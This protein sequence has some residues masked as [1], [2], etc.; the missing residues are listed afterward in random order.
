MSIFYVRK[1]GS[2]TH[3]T[4]LGAY[5]AASAGD[6]INIGEG[7]F[8]ESVEVFKQN[9]TFTG[10]GKD[11]TIIQ[12]NYV[13]GAIS[14]ATGCSWTLGNNFFTYTAQD[15][16]TNYIP[17]AVGMSVGDTSATP[18][19]QGSFPPGSQI[20]SVDTVNKK[21]FI[22]KNFIGTVPS[23][24]TVK[25]YGRQATLEVRAS[26]FTISGIK[27]IDV[28]GS[29]PASSTECAAIYLGAN[30]AIFG[31]S[32]YPGSHST[33]FNINNC[34]IVAD[35][36]SAILAEGNVGVGNGIVDS[37]T[38]TGKTFT[39]QYSP[40]GGNLVKQA[41]AF[42][43]ANLPV[44]FT[45]NKLDVICG[46]MTNAATPVYGGNQIA[47]IDAY[48]SVVSGNQFK[49]KAVDPSGSYFNMTGLALRMRGGNSTASNNVIKGFNGFVTGGYLILPAYSN[50]SGKTI[51]VGEVVTTSS[52]FFK[53]TQAHVYDAANKA[54][55]AVSS[56]YWVELTGTP[57]QLAALLIENGK[58]NYQ[59]NSGTNVTITKLLIEV[60]QAAA[61]SFTSASMGKDALKTISKVSSS[62][63]FSNESN[64]KL[65]NYVFKHSSSSR[66]LVSSFRSDF[67]S[68]KKAKLKTN[69]K[70]GDT[71]ELQKII[72]SKADRTHLV[73][74]RSEISEA[75]DYDFSLLND[76]PAST[77]PESSILVGAYSSGS[78]LMHN[79]Y[80]LSITNEGQSFTL[81]SNSYATSVKVMLCKYSPNGTPLTGKI[82][83]TLKSSDFSGSGSEITSSNF[84]DLSTLQENTG[85]DGGTICEFTFNSPVLLSAGVNSIK[86]VYSDSNMNAY[87]PFVQVFGYSPSV[88]AGGIAYASG[89][90]TPWV[91]FW[92]QVIGYSA[93]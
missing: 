44:T 84:V 71:F 24:K 30:S 91:D 17:F 52:R 53:C 81:D 39:G 14:Q 72:I 6:T 37:C 48:G 69:M 3:T 80:D 87:G 34:E 29:V 93:V 58:A 67:N 50:L 86:Y 13:S 5:M 85:L 1:D 36:D 77:Q 57:T 62:A 4:I 82:R 19:I 18:A 12:G 38:I 51:P 90:Q 56:A 74:K 40:G 16:R 33:G 46:G 27:V 41:V 83:M 66:R 2:G 45:N 92:F 73:I 26:G 35:G 79:V 65:V 10:A 76:G 21:V 61:N 49:G 55:T 70:A 88:N 11:K 15:T 32:K 9:L 89:S 22:N 78:T 60:T 43:S 25:H 75:S 7:T 23:G 8:T 64:W 63:V 68:I 54:P 42:Q 28:A 20:T 31:T 47:T 59:A